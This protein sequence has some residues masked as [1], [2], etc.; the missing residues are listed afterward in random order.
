MS[1]PYRPRVIANERGA[2]LFTCKTEQAQE[3]TD[4]LNHNGVF[5]TLTDAETTEN[6]E[7]EGEQEVY[8]VRQIDIASPIE[9]GKAKA[10]IDTW[11]ESRRD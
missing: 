1:I 5:A 3:M 9:P 10:L 7:F 8:T 2:Y 4:F 11:C 6:M